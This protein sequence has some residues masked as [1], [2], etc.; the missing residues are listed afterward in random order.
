[1]SGTILVGAQ[2]GDEGKGKIT[3]LIAEGFDYV[4][5][6]QGGNNAGHTVVHGDVRLALHLVPSGILYPDVT[7][8]IGNGCVVDPQVLLAE[9]D[10]L[11]A[12]GIPTERLLI[13]G[14]THLIMPWHLALDAASEGRLG[15]QQIGTT[16]RGI[17]PAY[18]E[19]LGRSGLR[20]Q[21]LLDADHFRAKV[22]AA[23]ESA[24]ALLTRVYG[25]EPCDAGQV[26]EEY[27]AMGR[28]IIPHVA[29][30]A[31][32]LNSELAAGKEVLFEGAQGT[33]L[34]IDHGTYPYVTSSSCTAGGAL[35]GSGVGPLHIRRVLGVA[36]AYIT[37]VG[38]G[39]FPTELSDDIGERMAE[40]GGEY[41]T[42]TGRKRRCG[43]HDA[44]I[45]RYAAA[46]NGL[47]DLCITKLDVLGFCE[48]IKVCVA[49]EL[50]GQEYQALPNSQAVFQ[51]ARPVFE[52]WP[53]WL[54]DI[55]GC[56]R[57]EELP[58]EARAYV[59]RLEQLAGVPVSIVSVGPERDQ[60]ILRGWQ[61]S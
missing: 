53:G 21:D 10:G 26:A 56:R 40:L 50:D 16:R 38:S 33:L 4:V 61:H 15:E 14:S 19:K 28:R 49:Y 54:S 8:V 44:V 23:A 25:L 60:T 2:W 20:M 11:D 32:L 9:M 42:T 39:P 36:K 18:Q 27:L 5:R 24:N 3:D 7:P 1:M 22:A 34:D 35:T 17:G 45:T 55:S 59:E 52:E 31:L 6:Y 47:T 29:D 46:I 57:F 51:A 37:R 13:S 48:T 41:G 43:W 30:A 12:A 58:A